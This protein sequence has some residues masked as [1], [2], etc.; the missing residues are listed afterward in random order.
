MRRR[1][2]RG[3]EMLLIAARGL[4]SVEL[5]SP[6]SEHGGSFHDASLPEDVKANGCL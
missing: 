3:R 4:L 6:A 2:L 5:A 1:M